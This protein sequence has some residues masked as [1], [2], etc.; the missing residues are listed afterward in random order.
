MVWDRLEV[1]E[2]RVEVSERRLDVSE[3]RLEVQGIARGQRAF[4]AF[5]L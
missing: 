4:K 5:C 3:R 1:S 2:R